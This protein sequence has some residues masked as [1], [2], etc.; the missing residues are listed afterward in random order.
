MKV[1]IKSHDAANNASEETKTSFW[2]KTQINEFTVT[3][4][5]NLSEKSSEL[6]SNKREVT[7]KGTGDVGATVSIM[8][9]G[10]EWISQKIQED[11]NWQITLSDLPEDLSKLQFII[12]DLA[13]NEQKIDKTILIDS[14]PPEVPHVNEPIIFP[15]GEKIG[16]DGRAEVGATVIIADQHGNP[17]RTLVVGENGEWG[18]MIGYPTDGYFT[19]VVKDK[20]CNFS[21]K[22]T[23]KITPP[24]VL[25]EE[26][27]EGDKE[28]VG[29]DE[30]KEGGEDGKI[31]GEGEG[32][33]N[34]AEEEE[35]EEGEDNAEGVKIE[36]DTE[37]EE[38]KKGVKGAK[39][40]EGEETETD[41]KEI[42]KVEGKGDTADPL[43]PIATKNPE[44]SDTQEEETSAVT[45][46]EDTKE[47]NL[48]E[49]SISATDNNSIQLENSFDDQHT[50]SP[51]PIFMITPPEDSTAMKLFLDGDELEVETEKLNE[52]SISYTLPISLEEGSYTLAV[53]FFDHQ[54]GFSLEEK[55]FNIDSSSSDIVNTLDESKTLLPDTN[56]APPSG[57]HADATVDNFFVDSMIQPID[58]N[59]YE[60]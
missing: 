19:V 48:T 40:T 25:P 32:N 39:N 55:N 57:Q 31:I 43:T 54:G 6:W 34:S 13:G 26:N 53:K 27:G 38:N 51:R 3:M 22:L 50:N 28:K 42:E 5:D 47:S 37:N 56:T 18:T 36:E 35:N 17:L 10:Q 60:R 23:Q 46:A 1:S 12:K 33:E 41:V 29:G 14:Q 21:E 15:G 20:M 2:V 7:F 16:V 49:E 52:Q 58:D 24:V 45:E 44:L 30:G 59:D 9:G 11:K 8:L 4:E